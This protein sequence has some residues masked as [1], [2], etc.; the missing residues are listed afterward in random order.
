MKQK[1]TITALFAAIFIDAL[2]WGIAFPVLAPIILNNTT[3][4][5][6]P[7]T[8]AASRTF[9]YELALSI[10]CVFMFLMSPVLGSLSDKYGRK[11]ILI[12]SMLGNFI[13]F[14]VSAIAIPMNSFTLL[15]VGRSIAG[16]TAGSMPIAQAAAIDISSEEQKASRLGLMILGNVTGFALGP[17]IGGFFMDKAIFGTHIAYQNPFYISCA[18]GL[19]GALLLMFGFKET[20]KGDNSVKINVM[21][22]FVNMFEAFT[23]KKTL[24]YYFMLL[25]FLF[26]WGIFFTAIPVSLTEKLHWSGASI[27]FFISYLGVLFGLIIL[28]ILPRTTKKFQLSRIVFVALIALLSCNIIFPLIHNSILPWVVILLAMSVPFTYVCTVTLLSNH[29]DSQ[30]QGRMMG[31]VGSVFAFTWAIGPIV[32][33]AIVRLNSYA[34][35]ILAGACFILALIIFNT[36]HFLGRMDKA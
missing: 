12:L 1:L 23:N 25:C 15:L 33:G 16:A 3:G 9:Y 24:V 8:S 2:G 6:D 4:M 17:V 32:G 20:F 26:G 29:V 10:Y 35:F 21:T 30:H 7:A 27:G 34:P 13:G 19:M 31:I 5:L 36:K 14:L 22:G 18:M 28:F 11:N